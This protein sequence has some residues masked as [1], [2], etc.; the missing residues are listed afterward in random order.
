MGRRDRRLTLMLAA[1]LVL[2]V[3]WIAW[4]LWTLARAF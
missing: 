2:W 1:W 3:G 4:G